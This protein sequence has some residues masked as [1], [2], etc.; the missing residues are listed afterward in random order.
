M[1][2]GTDALTVEDW[3]ADMADDD[4]DAHATLGDMLYDPS[5]DQAVAAKIRRPFLPGIFLCR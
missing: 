3:G 1:V 5:V 2:R 4:I